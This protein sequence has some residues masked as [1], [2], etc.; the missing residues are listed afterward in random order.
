MKLKVQSGGR[1]HWPKSGER[2]RLGMSLMD[3]IF[4]ALMMANF[5][6]SDKNA[7]LE[8]NCTQLNG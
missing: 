7:Q 5:V 3:L 4:Q 2:E 6:T 1:L 8:K